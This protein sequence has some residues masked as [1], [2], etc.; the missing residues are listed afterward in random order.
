MAQVPITTAT[1]R[2]VCDNLGVPL[3]G[4]RASGLS[5]ETQERLQ[6]QLSLLFRHLSNS[7][8]RYVPAVAGTPSQCFPKGGPIPCPRWRSIVRDPWHMYQS[9]S[10]LAYWANLGSRLSRYRAKFLQQ[11]AILPS[12]VLF[13]QK[14]TP[15]VVTYWDSSL[16]LPLTLEGFSDHLRRINALSLSQIDT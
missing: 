12:A 5:L 11:H 2:A 16:T 15:Q 9:C 6:I 13:F 3:V 4:T 14:Q 10:F 1:F 7:I 8:E